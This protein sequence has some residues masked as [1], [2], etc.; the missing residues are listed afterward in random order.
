METKMKITHIGFTASSAPANLFRTL[1]R[2]WHRHA[3]D[4]SSPYHPER[5]YMRGPGPKSREKHDFSEND[6]W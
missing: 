1:A 4:F 2:R 6:L 3:A 5:H